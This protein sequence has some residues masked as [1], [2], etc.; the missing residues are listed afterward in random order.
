MELKDYAELAQRIL[1]SGTPY[2]DNKKNI[3]PLFGK[4]ATDEV[5]NDEDFKKL[6]KNRLKAVNRVYSITSSQG[7][8]DLVDELEDYS[9]NQLK[10]FSREFLNDPSKDPINKLIF[11]NKYG[12]Y[13][14]KGEGRRAI[15]LVSAYLCFLTGDDFPICNNPAKKSYRVIKPKRSLLDENNFFRN[16]KD[17]NEETGI[18]DYGT[19]DNLLWSMGQTLNGS[20]SHI[21]KKE[22]YSALVELV[23][24]KEKDRIRGYVKEN[25][26]DLDLFTKD[27]KKFFEFVFDL[28]DKQSVGQNR[29]RRLRVILYN[30]ILNDE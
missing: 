20:L 29:R 28:K 4:E 21:M 22:K 1:E 27:Q 18:K 2:W 16:I 8:D 17:L 6:V 13:K 11:K 25:Y 12:A 30:N 3:K 7:I 14:P 19:L 23:E 15:S 10:E 9:D 5:T 24:S 26:K